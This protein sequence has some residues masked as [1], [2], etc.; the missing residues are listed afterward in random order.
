MAEIELDPDPRSTYGATEAYKRAWREAFAPEVD[1]PNED[2]RYAV[3]PGNEQ[4]AQT[5]GTGAG[6]TLP[7]SP[8]P[9]AGTNSGSATAPQPK[10]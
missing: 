4:A 9:G 6:V 1:D 5:Q 10:K 3:A 8:E 2:E 7:N